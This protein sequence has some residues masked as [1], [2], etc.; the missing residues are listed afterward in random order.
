M[1]ICNFTLLRKDFK[2]KERKIDSCPEQ[3]Y[4]FTSSLAVT[5]VYFRGKMRERQK[6]MIMQYLFQS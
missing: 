4:T 3:H 6:S 2:N 5:R 1:L